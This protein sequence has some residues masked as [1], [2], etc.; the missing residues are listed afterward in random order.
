MRFISGDV[1][2][3]NLCVCVCEKMETLQTQMI[4]TE[5]EVKTFHTELS[6]LRRSY[7]SLEITRESLI[8]EVAQTKAHFHCGWLADDT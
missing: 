3:S 6:E 8:K 7:Q 1:T 4:T 2:G 5:T